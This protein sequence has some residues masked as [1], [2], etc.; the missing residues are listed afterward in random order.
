MYIP[1]LRL[2]LLK[3]HERLVV[4][5]RGKLAVVASGAVW[6]R[7][8]PAQY[9]NLDQVF[10]NWRELPARRLDEYIVFLAYRLR[11]NPFA[12]AL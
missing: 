3:E 6:P 9:V 5:R 4:F 12:L 11:P 10:P 1:I 8:D 7:G 2:Y